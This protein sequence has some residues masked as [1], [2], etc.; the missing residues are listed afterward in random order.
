MKNDE[1]C[2]NFTFLNHTTL[3][4]VDIK[5]FD[6]F[7]NKTDEEFKNSFGNP[8]RNLDRYMGIS[9]IHFVNEKDFKPKNEGTDALGTY[10]PIDPDWRRPVIK[11]CPE[12]VF[13]QV[14]SNST[15]LSIK[16]NFHLL[17]AAVTV[18]EAAHFLMDLSGRESNYPRVP[19]D[20]A[21]DH[22]PEATSFADLCNERIGKYNRELK[23]DLDRVEESLANAIMLKQKAFSNS[24]ISYLKEF[25]DIQPECYKSSLKWIGTLEQTLATAKNFARFKQSIR[26]NYGVKKGE[27]EMVNADAKLQE[28][29]AKIDLNNTISLGLEQ[30]NFEIN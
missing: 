27:G 10:T 17:I 1:M 21:I 22:M 6:F 4:P 19:L 26:K 9:P 13:A 16:D 23:G 30:E 3:L 15:A 20:W 24:E 18:H 5:A 25:I 29:L 12:K 14:K 8:P 7:N 11:V 2:P 28:V